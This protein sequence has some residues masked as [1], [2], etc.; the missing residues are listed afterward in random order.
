CVRGERA[1]SGSAGPTARPPNAA[2]AAR[3]F[4]LLILSMHPR[5][6]V[7]GL[8]DHSAHRLDGCSGIVNTPVNKEWV[9][10]RSL[11]PD[12]HRSTSNVVFAAHSQTGVASIPPPRCIY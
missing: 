9:S 5:I 8:L 7:Q 12:Q 4:R 1:G 3:G 2:R 11:S 6:C 10:L